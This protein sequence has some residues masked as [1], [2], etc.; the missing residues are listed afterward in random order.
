MPIARQYP[1]DTGCG[2]PACP[3][4]ARQI[5]VDDHRQVPLTTVEERPHRIRSRGHSRQRADPIEGRRVERARAADVEPA[6]RRIHLKRDQA[7]GSLGQIF[8][9]SCRFAS[10]PA[11]SPAAI[12]STNA[13]ATCAVTSPCRNLA[14]PVAPVT[15]LTKPFSVAS[16]A[17]RRLQRRYHAE[18]RSGGERHRHTEKKDSRVGFRS[19][20]E[21]S[22]VRREHAEERPCCGH[23]E[24]EAERGARARQQE[25][26][27]EQLPG[28]TCRGR[29][30][31][32]AARPF[33]A[34][35]RRPVP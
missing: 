20:H 3:L 12:N 25:T 27:H 18:E 26:L 5:T 15:A 4:P 10:E 6:F 7:P 30:L 8:S 9:C 13:S 22:A 32:P 23:C 34:A 29:P 16:G 19:Q 35:A 2:P 28:S 24:H 17:R 21:R 31:L 33:P 14:D 1:G 11:N